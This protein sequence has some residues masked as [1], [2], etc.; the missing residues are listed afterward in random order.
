[1]ARPARLPAI[2]RLVASC[3]CPRLVDGTRRSA[4]TVRDHPGSTAGTTVVITSPHG[5]TDLTGMCD[6]S[7]AMA[8]G[9]PGDGSPTCV[10]GRPE[11]AH[12][13]M[14]VDPTNGLRVARPGGDRRTSPRRPGT[15]VGGGEPTVPRRSP[16]QLQQ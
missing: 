5:H 13:P 12:P 11:S 7:I 16:P 3:A 9:G 15:T 4:S 14:V 2:R 6:V 8:L 1:M 10:A